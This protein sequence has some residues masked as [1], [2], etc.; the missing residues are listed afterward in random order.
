M[1][2]C[3]CVKGLPV[4]GDLNSTTFHGLSE[5]DTLVLASAVVTA[6]LLSSGYSSL[7]FSLSTFFC[8][9]FVLFNCRLLKQLAHI[10]ADEDPHDVCPLSDNDSRI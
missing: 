8:V 4:L 10:T 7:I 6:F 2:R 1:V 3:S 9:S 5:R